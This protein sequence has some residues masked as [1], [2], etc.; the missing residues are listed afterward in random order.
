MEEMNLFGSTNGKEEYY[1]LNKDEILATF[2]VDDTIDMPVI[3]RIIGV[4]PDWID[5]LSIFIMNRRAPKNRE[6]ISEL[7]KL[8]GC[9]T[10]RGYLEITHALSLIDTFWVKPIDS[11]LTWN[12]VSLYTH[13]FNE[14]IA[15]TAFEGGLHG[16]AFSSTSPEYGTDGTFAKCWIRENGTIKMLKRGSS[17]AR[18]AGLEPYSEYYASQIISNFTR[19][20][21]DYGLRTHKSRICSVCDC[22]TSEKYGY[23]PYAAIDKGNTNF[24]RVLNI[25]DK[26]GLADKARLMFVVDAVIFNEDRHKNNFGFI[27]DNDKQEIVDMA[28]LFDHNISLLPYAEEEEFANLDNYLSQKGPRLGNDFFKIARYCL[29]S[30]TRNALTNLVGFRFKR[31][32]K[33][34]LP[35]WRLECLEALVNDNI[36]KILS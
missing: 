33:Y 29:T 14:T 26:Y 13:P 28:P 35:E 10:L 6:N 30:E 34:N 5:D 8:S 31:H 15:K 21:V 25:M 18:N 27:I 20:Y 4:I 17:G 3:N 2:H 12:R 36:K 23:L 1:L 32:P 19:H 9:D 7:L 11:K 22:F 16:L 24:M